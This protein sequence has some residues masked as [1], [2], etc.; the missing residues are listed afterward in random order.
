MTNQTGRDITVA[1]S[2]H[3]WAR[4]K[5]WQTSKQYRQSAT[6]P[7]TIE[8]PSIAA[9]DESL[10]TNTKVRVTSATAGDADRRPAR[11]FGRIMSANI[12]KRD[13]TTPPAK[14]RVKYSTFFAPLLTS[15]ETSQASRSSSSSFKGA[16]MALLRINPTRLDR[17]VASFVS[18]F[19]NPPVEAVAR[20]LTWGADEHVLLAGAGL[21]WLITRSS[22][23]LARRTFGS[24]LVLVSLASSI[25]PHLLKAEIDQKRPDRVAVSGN[26]RGIRFSGK[27]NDAFPSGHAIHMGAIASAATLLPPTARNAVWTAAGV[28][29][30]TRIAILA[31]WTTDVLAGFVIGVGVERCLRWWTRP[32]SLRGTQD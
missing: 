25:L 28:L 4:T 13:T 29:S 1:V 8:R 16:P 32:V 2:A 26:R 22:G 15:E 9:Y 6:L 3:T 7:K 21:I 10:P 12:A 31:H 20:T 30:A 18:E 19:T 5:S 27:A 23:S 17:Q 11:L 24:H 14:K